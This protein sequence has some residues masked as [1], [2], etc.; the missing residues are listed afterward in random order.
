M[1]LRGVHVQ[2]L[3]HHRP[4]SGMWLSHVVRVYLESNADTAS[5]GRRGRQLETKSHFDMIGHWVVDQDRRTRCALC[6]SQTS[7][8][9]EKCQ[10]GVH[11]K[12][13]R[14]YRIR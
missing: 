5:Q 3:G 10:K 14:E 8:R 13:F 2:C 6:Q 11:A 1:Q 12:C 9:G 4:G 7:T